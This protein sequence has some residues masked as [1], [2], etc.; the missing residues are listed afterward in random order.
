[1]A[2]NVVLNPGTGGAT[3][4]ADDIGGI[5]HQ[6]VKTGFGP[7][8]SY[9]DVSLTN[10]QPVTE[11][12]SSA[13]GTISAADIVAALPGE[14]G[15]FVTG[16]PTANSA[17]FCATPG[18]DSAFTI[19]LTGTFS[20][21]YWFELSY[22]STN[23]TDGKWILVKAKQQG[24]V[25]EFLAWSTT[26]EGAYRGN[27]AGAKYV[28]VRNTGGTSSWSTAVIITMSAGVAAI[29][30]SAPTPEGDKKIGRTSIAEMFPPNLQQ[31]AIEGYPLDGS[32]LQQT[33]PGLI[34]KNG[35]ILTG[36]VQ[37]ARIGAG[38]G[39][40]VEEICVTSSGGCPLA[41]ANNLLTGSFSS[42][43]TNGVEIM[44]GELPFDGGSVTQKVQRFLYEGSTLVLSFIAV[45]TGR[46]PRISVTARGISFTD[47]YNWDAKTIAVMIGTSID[48]GFMGID[49][50]TSIN[51]TN[52]WIHMY[53][54]RD[55]M[56][57]ASKSMRIIN[58]AVVGAESDMWRKQVQ[59]GAFG[60]INYDLLIVNL[61]I[62]DV[63]AGSNI[64]TTQFEANLKKFI[65]HRNR[66]R[67]GASI[68]FMTPTPT[69]TAVR[70]GIGPYRT[71]VAT[72]ANDATLG[73]TARNVYLCDV[74]AAWVTATGQATGLNPT[75]TA[76]LNFA[77]T[78][79]S[80]G[81]RVHQSGAGM[82]ITANALW[83][84]LQTTNYYKNLA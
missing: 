57:D 82:T 62:N 42:F 65:V 13:S 44:Y 22:D 67:P 33:T 43:Q 61:G 4:A 30:Q 17:V 5:L 79:R 35:A 25:Q 68:I 69:D 84:T 12:D 11:V 34:A 32:F 49:P 71:S 39:A 76:D 31:L 26:R 63:L 41:W 6:R 15:L 21:K 20:G 24:H 83:A 40:W 78:E 9:T 7:D 55:K 81:N 64:T 75:A 45:E 54:V 72:V 53:Q 80:A 51:Y 2:D 47:D 18:G 66:F 56:H 70:S 27:L 46:R 16:V 1:M 14:D 74:F 8:G 23:G 73:G 60:G 52:E 58:K 28:R 59:S 50:A 77:D 48:G 36:T 3:M 19:Q 37:L 29:F 38:K 10:P